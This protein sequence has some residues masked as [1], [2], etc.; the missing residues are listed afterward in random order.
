MGVGYG[1]EPPYKVIDSNPSFSTVVSSFNFTDIA[2]IFSAGAIGVPVG[3]FSG[4]EDE[5]PERRLC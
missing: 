3:Y 4:N 5:S 1:E 2:T